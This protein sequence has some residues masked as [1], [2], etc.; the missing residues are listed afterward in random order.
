MATGGRTPLRVLSIGTG[1]GVASGFVDLPDGGGLVRVGSSLHALS[2]DEYKLWDAG[3]LAPEA[4]T[5]LEQAGLN[6]VADPAA[7]L[8]ELETAR[9]VL[10]DTGEPG[11]R[12]ALAA[13]L[14]VRL[15]GRLI[16][17]GPHQ[18]PSFLVAA[19][20]ATTQLRVDPV[21]Y[22]V[23]LWADGRTSL[24][25]LCV[26]IDTSAADPAFDVA[27]YVV[28]WIPQLLRTGLIGLDLA[29]SPARWPR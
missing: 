7:V 25:D 11:S 28:G 19:S 12:R 18:S 15:T 20:G 29:D 13:G 6:G 10:T 16:G 23:L 24:A 22:Q 27:Q 3:Q 21:I 8:A 5:L 17:N 26:R 14:S 4:G 9:L 2:A 1:G